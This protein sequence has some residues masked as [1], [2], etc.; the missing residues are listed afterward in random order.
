MRT[1]LLTVLLLGSLLLPL[2]VLAESDQDLLDALGRALGNDEAYRLAL[3][4]VVRESRSSVRLRRAGL[5]ALGMLNTRE[6]A[7]AGQR[8]FYASLLAG[9]LPESLPEIC[10]GHLAT[11]LTAESGSVFLAKRHIAQLAAA[12]EGDLRE[13][14]ESQVWLMGDPMARVP[15]LGG[16]LHEKGL[17]G[18]GFGFTCFLGSALRDFPRAPFPKVSLDRVALS[19]RPSL[20]DV[21]PAARRPETEVLCV[22]S[23]YWDDETRTRFVFRPRSAPDV[24][25][26]DFVQENRS[27]LT[28]RIGP[29]APITFHSL[30]VFT[31]FDIEPWRESV[32]YARAR[33]ARPDWPERRRLIETCRLPIGTDAEP[34]DIHSPY[35]TERFARFY[36]AMDEGIARSILGQAHR[37]AEQ[38]EWAKARSTYLRVVREFGSNQSAAPALE[39]LVRT[40]LKEDRKASLEDNVLRFVNWVRE[41]ASEKGVFD[42]AEFYA[43]QF[44]YREKAY[45]EALAAIKLFKREHAKDAA[46]LRR[47]RLLE[48]LVRFRSD[49]LEDALIVFRALVEEEDKDEIAAQSQFL[50]GWVHLSFQDYGAARDA[51]EKVVGRYPGSDHAKKAQELLD[52]IPEK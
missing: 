48:G 32:S 17:P 33:L 8:G 20:A 26:A 2:A 44:L 3:T 46:H 18:R 45:D 27:P 34:A 7:W 51:L 38:G 36:A 23:P 1:R 42:T 14:L 21:C 24:P 16:M 41:H 40:F 29:D 30:R 37:H 13:V 9:D 10:A 25:L 15:D 12:A 50:I 6:R 31:R 19:E 43:C 5:R 22:E 28:D 49:Q 52:R 35:G 39:G 11:A 47:A 4:K